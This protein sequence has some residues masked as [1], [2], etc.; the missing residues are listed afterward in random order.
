M[1]RAQVCRRRLPW[2]HAVILLVLCIVLTA[3]PWRRRRPVPEPVCGPTVGCGVSSSRD[4][5][6][7]ALHSVFY[8]AAQVG[9]PH[10]AKG[11]APIP[12][13]QAVKLLRCDP[14]SVCT[15]RIRRA[16]MKLSAALVL[17]RCRRAPRTTTD[18]FAEA[19][20][21]LRIPDILVVKL[22]QAGLVCSPPSGPPLSELESRAGTI[23][24]TEEDL[25]SL[26][27]NCCP[28]V[29]SCHIGPTTT[30]IALAEF[31]IHVVNRQAQCV[32][33]AIDPQ[34]WKGLV[35]LNF[36]R[37]SQLDVECE[38]GTP[39]CR[40][41]IICDPELQAPSDKPQPDQPAMPWCGLL[42]EQVKVSTDGKTGHFH[43]VLKVKTTKFSAS[44]TGAQVIPWY[45]LDYGLCES[46]DFQVCTPNCLHDY[47]VVR[48]D[49]GEALVRPKNASDAELSGTKYLRFKDR[50][51]G[52]LDLN[53]WTPLALEVLVAETALAACRPMADR[54]PAASLEGCTLPPSSMQV[55]CNCPG[56]YDSCAQETTMTPKSTPQL[57][58]R[59]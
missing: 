50:V 44:R 32:F 22:W 57:C 52:G 11:P 39:V 53:G 1:S 19:L 34:C 8:H 38:D 36:D 15:G 55:P 23:I 25:A 33:P 51:A 42:A 24:D 7:A 17:Q 40:S 16:A 31:T 20:R 28:C 59:R 48:V 43:Q 47:C 45:R 41:H 5:V 2:Q 18:D 49:C 14:D 29:T 27:R 37:S 10:A 9:A 3:C 13:Q 54:C 26:Q 30:R 46:G 58:P 35:P 21:L 4:E 56:P 6:L 12:L